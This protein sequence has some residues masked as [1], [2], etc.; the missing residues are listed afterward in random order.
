VAKHIRSSRRALAFGLAALLCALA[1]ALAAATPA[2]AAPDEPTLTVA[3]LQALLDAS[4]GG[5]VDG[6][7]KTVL[8][9]SE[10]V[11]I[12]VT[13]QATVPYSIPEG[14]L[15]LFQARGPAIEA[16]G[17][18]AHGMSGSPLYVDDG[19]VD[20]LVGA[21]AY[22]DIFTKGYLGLATPVEYMAAMEDTFLPAAPAAVGVALRQPLPALK[23]QRG[24]LAGRCAR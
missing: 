20:A 10:I 9:G 16:I 3:E 18:I 17:G 14:S 8:K 22:G 19:G 21:V 1:L 15:V 12:P 23:T 6:Y 5:T 4:P 2:T 11:R 7:F 13:V 24:L